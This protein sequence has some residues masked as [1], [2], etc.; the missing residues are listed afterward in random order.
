MMGFRSVGV[1]G[2]G[3]WGTA[4]AQT[5][6][7]AGCDVKIWAREAA[8][9]EAINQRHE[10]TIFLPGVPL[11]PDIVASPD[12]G[13]LAACDVLLLVVP[14]QF[15]RS[16]CQQLAP[17][18][19]DGL[20]VVICAKGIEQD[21]GKLLTQVVGEALPKARQAVLS[22]PCFAADVSRN[23]PTAVTLA[24]SEEELGRQLIATIG[25]KTFRPYLTDDMTGAEIGG[26]VKN[27][28]AIAAG[29][30]DGKDL[31]ASA[32]AAL[33]TRGFAELVRFGR[34]H[35][36]RPE[37]LRGLSGL[38]DLILTSSSPL[39]RNMSLGQGLGRGERLE[40]ILGARNSVSEGVYT[41]AAVV[42]IARE[43]GIEMPI[44][45]AVHAIIGG[46]MSVDEAIDTLL[47]RPF[48]VENL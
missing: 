12:L 46:R 11:D 20:P 28:L 48:K 10:N 40:D 35:G 15:V 39:S 37:T 44:C 16:V 42:R 31:G 47:S 21:S 22:G 38:G 2:A 6:R 29:I 18:I 36:A 30:V 8:V 5:A 32:R 4:L 45:E 7:L 24:C 1:V 9:A 33:V 43:K 25:H 14:A 19:E 27:V 13:D 3:A 26:A 17:L 23:K 41:A 34:A